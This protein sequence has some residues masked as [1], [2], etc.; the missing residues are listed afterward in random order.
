MFILNLEIVLEPRFC[1]GVESRQGMFSGG[2]K[3]KMFTKSIQKRLGN[4]GNQEDDL[5]MC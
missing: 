4:V 1:P 2:I 5:G 3:I